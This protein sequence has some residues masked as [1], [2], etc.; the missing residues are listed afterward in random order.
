MLWR[1]AWRRY[2]K[3]PSRG[4]LERKFKLTHYPLRSLGIARS[5]R[6]TRVSQARSR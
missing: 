3:L 1:L 2:A 4:F 5:I 6:P